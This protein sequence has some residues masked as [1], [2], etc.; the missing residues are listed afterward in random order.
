MSRQFNGTSDYAVTT[1]T[2]NLSTY[3]TLT[4][5]GWMWWDVNANDDDSACFF[6]SSGSA[7]MFLWIPNHSGSGGKAEAQ[8]RGNVGLSGA[9]YT[10]PSAA[11]WHHYVLMFDMSSGSNEVVVWVDGASAPGL[12]NDGNNN[13][14]TSTFGNFLLAFMAN[15]SGALNA[16]GRLAGWGLWGRI[17]T[18]TERGNLAAGRRPVTVTAN[19]VAAWDMA[20]AG[21]SETDA[22]GNGHNLNYTGTTVVADPPSLDGVGGTSGGDTN[23]SPVYP[24]ASRYTGRF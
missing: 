19:L 18:T 24:V 3:N 7:G 13:D 1:A 15:T 5:A 2:L 9:S 14:N 4:L 20:A 8:H 22:S 12:G 17:L 16:A 21:S 6:G 11:A 10:R 23:H